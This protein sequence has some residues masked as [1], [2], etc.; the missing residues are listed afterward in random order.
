MVIFINI[1]NIGFS[2]ESYS[3]INKFNIKAG[4]WKD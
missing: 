1:F 4:E 2:L 3:I